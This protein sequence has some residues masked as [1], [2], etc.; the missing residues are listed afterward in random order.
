MTILT[1]YTKRLY[2]KLNQMTTPDDYTKRLCRR[3]IPNDYT[4]DYIEPKHVYEDY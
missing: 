1:D 4:K 3:A 2:K